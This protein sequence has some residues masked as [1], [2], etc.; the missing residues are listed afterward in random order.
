MDFDLLNAE[1]DRIDQESNYAKF[2]R[3]GWPYMEADDLEWNWHHDAICSALNRVNTG[4]TTRLIINADNTTLKSRLVTVGWPMFTWARQQKEGQIGGPSTKFL[5]VSHAEALFE[6][7]SIAARDLITSPWYQERWGDRVKLKSRSVRA[8][9]T[10]E[11]G[12]RLTAVMTKLMGLHVDVAIIDDPFDPNEVISPII[13]NTICTSFDN[14][15]QRRFRDPKKFAIIIVC[16]RTHIYDLCGHILKDKDRV[17]REGWEVLCLPARYEKKHPYIY[18][19]DPRKKEGEPLHPAREDDTALTKKEKSG[20]ASNWRAQSQQWP[21]KQEGSLFAG[22]ELHI[23][24]GKDIP[25]DLFLVRGW[26]LAHRDPETRPEEIRGRIHWTA[27]VLIGYERGPRR[28]K[29]ILDVVRVQKG[30]T[31]VQR[32]IKRTTELDN[33]GEH[34]VPCVLE[35]ELGAAGVNLIDTYRTLVMPGHTVVGSKAQDP[36]RGS[37]AMV[38]A[39]ENDEVFVFKGKWNDAFL[40]EMT[41]VGLGGEDDQLCAWM[42]A[43]NYAAK[44]MRHAINPG[45][46]QHPAAAGQGKS[47]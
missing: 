34:D 39:V 44:N 11:H 19:K 15:L 43:H 4:E 24:E 6:E 10:T 41:D 28:R 8:I 1:L 32:L 18:V 35:E 7:H 2:F 9:R 31:D 22:G 38:T 17:E 45:I 25:S 21:T 40:Q 12:Q 46:A 36:T 13:R 16:A 3:D 29:Y 30:P 42:H 26:D 20:R 14:T 5:C 37:T 47:Q 23:V 27:G 33:L